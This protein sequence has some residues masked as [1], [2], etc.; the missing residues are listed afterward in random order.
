[1]KSIDWPLV[2]VAATSLFGFGVQHQNVRD[3]SCKVDSLQST[4]NDVASLKL[5]YIVVLEELEKF[6][7]LSTKDLAGARELTGESPSKDNQKH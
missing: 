2:F 7:N 5:Q 6:Q 4:E 1:M 3:L